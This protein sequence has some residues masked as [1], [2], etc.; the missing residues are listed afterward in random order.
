MPSRDAAP[1]VGDTPSTDGGSEPSADRRLLIDGRLVTS[2]REHKTLAV[3]V[4]PVP[5]VA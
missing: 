4:V 2:D 5:G 3:P 1:T